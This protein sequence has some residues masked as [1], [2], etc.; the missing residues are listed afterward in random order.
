MEEVHVD[1]DVDGHPKSVPAGHGYR[2]TGTDA[3]HTL[4]E[5]QE[6]GWP[7]MEARGRET[8]WRASA[9]LRQPRRLR[10]VQVVHTVP[11]RL[12]DP[13]RADEA[14]RVQQ[15]RKQE[16]E[17]RR[18]NA[19]RSHT[20]ATRK[21]TGDARGKRRD[22]DTGTDEE[23]GLVV[24]EILG[25]G[26]EGPVDHHA[27]QDAVHGRVR[28]RA[29]EL[30]AGLHALLLRVEVAADRGRELPRKVADDTDMHRDVVFLRRAAAYVSNSLLNQI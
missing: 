22:A 29:D 10:V 20:L 16:T 1:V 9:H 27:R 11:D 18:Q 5:G 12:Q 30:P 14:Y 6:N 19:V 25:R 2:D 8:A 7:A 28:V 21:G 17:G 13:A 3:G 15:N 24:E 26:A 4:I 23:D